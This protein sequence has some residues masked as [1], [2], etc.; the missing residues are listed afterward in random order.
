MKQ[1]W[2][3]NSKKKN[4]NKIKYKSKKTQ[5]KLYHIKSKT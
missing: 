5:K 2:Q 4:L 1:K 3:L